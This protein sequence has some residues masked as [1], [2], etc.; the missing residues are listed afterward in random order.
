MVSTFRNV[1]DF[2]ND[3]GVYDVILPFLLVFTMI[4]AI[5]EKTKVFGTDTID[6]K[7][8]SKKSLNS[9]VAF[10]SAFFVVASAK[11]VEIINGTI[12]NVFILLLMAVLFLMVFGTF[13]KEGE[14]FWGAGG[15]GKSRLWI[16]GAFGIG[17][18]LIFLNAVGWLETAWD[19]LWDHWNSNAVASIILMIVVIAFMAWITTG[20]GTPAAEK[21]KDK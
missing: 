14:D 2:F 17:I 20:A 8:Y 18:I 19:Y 11:A 1:I 21:G 16:G 12:A 9:M 7:P 15:L 10:T 13:Y 3:L 5:L 6:G 4:F